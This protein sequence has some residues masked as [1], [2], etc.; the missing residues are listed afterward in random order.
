MSLVT[1]FDHVAIAVEDLARAVRLFQDV[2]G[3]EFVGGGDNPELKVRAIQLRLSPGVKVELLTPTTEDSY[4]R[5]YLD[6]HG[7]GFHHITLYTDDVEATAAA[8][9]G[10]GF[11]T[12]DTATERDSWHE[13]FL[14]PATAFGALVQVSRPAVPWSE[15]LVG[16]T[17]DDILAGRVE[18]LA[19]T[20]RWKDTREVILPAGATI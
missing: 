10:G 6:R 1:K 20:V 14:R 11:P 2:L 16:V 19:N 5:A 4:L 8:L 9:D 17:V 18:V 13:T 12:V 3:F 15:P 7:E